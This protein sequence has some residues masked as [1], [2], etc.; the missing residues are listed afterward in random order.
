MYLCKMFLNRRI[1]A[2]LYLVV[3][4]LLFVGCKSKFEKLRNSNN[5]AMKYQ[6]A[7]KFYENG[8]YSKALV[9]FDDLVSKYRGREEAEDLY[10]YLAYTNYRLRDYTSARFHFKRFAE[11]YPASPRAEECRFMSAYCYYVE[12]PRSSLDQANTRRAIDELQL[13]VNI[14]PESERAEEAAEL[15]QDLRDKLEKKAFDNA[16]LYYDMGTADDYRAA[17]IA[18]ENVLKTYPDTKYAEE[19]EFLMTKSQ[20]LYADNSYPN[21]QEER[22]N[23]AITY[24]NQFVAQ[25]PDSKFRSEANNLRE[26]AEKKIVV[27]IRRMEEIKK[28]REEQDRELGVTTAE[29]LAASSSAQ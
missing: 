18:F 15:I 8:K 6:E 12:S 24:Y 21:R 29:D 16:K 7:V 9:L 26:S 11:T 4:A 25:Y 2:F 23:Q 14:Y 20:Y 1:S 3:F 5:I 13:F 19:I 27:A 28:A 10:Y 22:F 17:V